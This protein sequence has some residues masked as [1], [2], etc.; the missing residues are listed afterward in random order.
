MSSSEVRLNYTSILSRSRFLLFFSIILS[1]L[2]PHLARLFWV[3][4][5]GWEWVT[6]YFSGG[7]GGVLYFSAFNLIPGGLWYVSG[8]Q[9]KNK[10]LAFW[11]SV[12]AGL[13]FLLKAHGTLD[14]ESSSTAAIEM[15][16]TPLFSGAVILIGFILGYL[17]DFAL[18]SAKLQLWTIG[19]IIGLVIIC[20]TPI[21]DIHWTLEYVGNFWHIFLFFFFNS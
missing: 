5:H 9:G 7:I 13:A 16:L 4:V 12:A 18:R 10:P 20:G 6:D 3:P 8:V 17:I 15:M 11:C 14:L 19:I 21:H 1:L 2:I